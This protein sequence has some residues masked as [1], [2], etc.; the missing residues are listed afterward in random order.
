[1]AM[2]FNQKIDR[3]L[4]L[5][6]ERAFPR[7]IRAVTL[8]EIMQ[9][10]RELKLATAHM[11]AWNKWL[12][13]GEEAVLYVP[14]PEGKV[15]VPEVITFDVYIDRYISLKWI[16]DGEPWLV[17]A[18]LLPMR[19]ELP[20]PFSIYTY[21]EVTVR[22]EHPA[23]DNWI[24]IGGIANWI[25]EPTWRSIVDDIDRLITEIEIKRF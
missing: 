4:A 25:H 18:Q 6:E 16:R 17:D 7:S 14:V 11:F 9:C 10:L 15:K 19:I 8:P 23:E 1:M 21:G 20:K 24:K 13:P 2:P 22:N 3:V 12:S 5:L